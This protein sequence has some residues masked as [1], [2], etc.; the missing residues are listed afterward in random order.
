[1]CLLLKGFSAYTLTDY[2]TFATGSQT[3]N[4]QMYVAWSHKNACYSKE[5]YINY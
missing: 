5:I 3:L 1:M 2:G 4:S